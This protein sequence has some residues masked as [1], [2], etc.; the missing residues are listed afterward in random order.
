MDLIEGTQ[1]L[2]LDLR[3]DRKFGGRMQNSKQLGRI[4]CSR[5]DTGSLTG[6]VTVQALRL[7]PWPH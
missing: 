1:L 2:V 5:V 7:A 3:H 4:E 6:S